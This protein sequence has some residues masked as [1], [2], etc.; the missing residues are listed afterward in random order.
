MPWVTGKPAFFPGPTLSGGIKT[1]SLVLV[2]RRKAPSGTL[3]R[4][5]MMYPA[6]GPRQLM[7]RASRDLGRKDQM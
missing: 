7:A 1:R 2:E 5:M 3:V 4:A 6:S